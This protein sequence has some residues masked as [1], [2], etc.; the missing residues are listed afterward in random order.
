ML[1][2][3]LS[4][5]LEKSYVMHWDSWH[6]TINTDKFVLSNSQCKL[7]FTQKLLVLWSYNL[8]ADWA[9]TLEFLSCIHLHIWCDSYYNPNPQI[10]CSLDQETFLMYFFI[11]VINIWIHLPVI[12]HDIFRYVRPLPIQ[13]NYETLYV[14]FVRF[15]FQKPNFDSFMAQY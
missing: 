11:L 6:Q 7:I 5:S 4:V 13:C 3:F 12:S 8:N 1:A 10:R 2:C 14:D 9:K 15:F